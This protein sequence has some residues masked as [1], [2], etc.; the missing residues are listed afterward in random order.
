MKI[1]R[2]KNDKI[3]EEYS[4]KHETHK[5]IQEAR[6]KNIIPKWIESINVYWSRARAQERWAIFQENV[7]WN[8]LF[9]LA[10]MYWSWSLFVN[11]Q[12]TIE[13]KL[14][15][16]GIIVYDFHGWNIIFDDEF[17]HNY[18]NATSKSLFLLLYRFG[19]IKW[20]YVYINIDVDGWQI[21]E[22]QPQTPP[23]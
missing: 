14:Q 16:I 23:S 9:K 15:K 18:R 20:W 12:R 2:N 7:S 3:S 13:K 4:L 8:T 10:Y 17:I 1:F 11:I 6:R 5:L 21:I 22:P 19:F